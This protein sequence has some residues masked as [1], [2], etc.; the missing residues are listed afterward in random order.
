M[1]VEHDQLFAVFQLI[2]P[3]ENFGVD[4]ASGGFWGVNFK[5]DDVEIFGVIL[6]VLQLK[7]NF[8]GFDHYNTWLV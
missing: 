6:R 7:T 3:N 2:V 5:L 8:R 1:K 4:L